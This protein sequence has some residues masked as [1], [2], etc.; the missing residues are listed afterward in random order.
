MSMNLYLIKEIASFGSSA[1]MTICASDPFDNAAS[2]E[3]SIAEH[4]FNTATS[5]EDLLSALQHMETAA[6]LISATSFYPDFDFNNWFLKH[7][8][9]RNY[10]DLCF[11][12]AS[13][14][15]MLEKPY[16]RIKY[17]ADNLLLRTSV[18]FP[19]GFRNLLTEE[20]YLSLENEHE[21]WSYSGDDDYNYRPGDPFI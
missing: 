4:Y 14:N 5:R 10:N 19:E 6:S 2:N 13:L 15:K 16:S 20:D 7:K 11:K 18:G 9:A 17:W 1:I 12:I 8:K 3:L 21:R